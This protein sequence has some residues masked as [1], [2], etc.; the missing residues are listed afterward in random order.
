MGQRTSKAVAKV[1]STPLWWF[2]T[3]IYLMS[4]TNTLSTKIGT[5]TM[6]YPMFLRKLEYFTLHFSSTLVVCM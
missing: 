4:V 1:S 6:L 3:S 2:H 5:N